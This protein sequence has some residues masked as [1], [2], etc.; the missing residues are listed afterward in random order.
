ML[1][2]HELPW[3]PLVGSS[4]LL[5]WTLLSWGGLHEDRAWGH[6]SE[7]LRLFVQLACGAA[8]IALGHTLVV[9]GLGWAGASTALVGLPRLWR[10]RGGPGKEGKATKTMDAEQP[11]RWTTFRQ[12]GWSEAD[13]P[14][15]C[16]VRPRRWP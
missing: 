2:A 6:R 12:S 13:S 5:V 9:I 7:A 10:L 3:F 15:R 14:R 4:V 8:A 16:D 1:T 11:A